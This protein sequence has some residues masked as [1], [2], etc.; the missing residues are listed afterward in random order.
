MGTIDIFEILKKYPFL[1]HFIGPGNVDES[2]P[3]ESVVEQYVTSVE[4]RPFKSL[5]PDNGNTI[6]TNRGVIEGTDNS[7]IIIS[8][9]HVMTWQNTRYFVV[10]TQGNEKWAHRVQWVNDTNSDGLNDDT[11]NGV[12]KNLLLFAKRLR[13]PTTFCYVVL[14]SETGNDHKGLCTQKFEIYPFKEHEH[15]Q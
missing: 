10:Y 8:Q 11:I 2:R 9:R 5:N 1:Y 12:I 13:R 3:T 4:V 7:E 14:V 6:S 15:K